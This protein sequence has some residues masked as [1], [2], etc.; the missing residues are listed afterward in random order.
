MRPRKEQQRTVK[1]DKESND[2]MKSQL[3]VTKFLDDT[4]LN[5]ST[6]HYTRTEYKEIP[7]YL[8]NIGIKALK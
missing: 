8:T 7:G 6:G 3:S 5:T 1:R 4:F 2:N